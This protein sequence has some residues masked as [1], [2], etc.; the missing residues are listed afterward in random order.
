MEMSLGDYDY[1]LLDPNYAHNIAYF[2]GWK[3]VWVGLIVII[4]ATIWRLLVLKFGYFDTRLLRISKI[5][6]IT[7]VL[8]GFVMMFCSIALANNVQSLRNYYHSK[9]VVKTYTIYNNFKKPEYASQ[10]FLY[11]TDRNNQRSL[12]YSHVVLSNKIP[13]G[14]ENYFK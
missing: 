6:S 13:T 1:R 8:S 12:E 7:M 5:I 2:S 11:K 4:I 10:V 3:M 9:G 14:T